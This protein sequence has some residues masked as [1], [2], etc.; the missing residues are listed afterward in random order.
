[1]F[2]AIKAG[3]LFYECIPLILPQ[4]HIHICLHP[5]NNRWI[6]KS[7]H[8]T[9]F[10]FFNNSFHSDVR[11]NTDEKIRLPLQCDYMVFQ[12]KKCCLCNL[13]HNNLLI[14]SEFFIAK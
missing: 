3:N 12:R 7:S 4:A 10:F 9:F 2:S 1:M 5:V 13:K 8:P 6:E 11:H 14:A